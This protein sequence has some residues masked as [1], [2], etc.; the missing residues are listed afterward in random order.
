MH[1]HMSVSFNIRQTR[2][3]LLSEVQYKHF[4]GFSLSVLLPTNERTGIF[5]CGRCQSC[6]IRCC[7][8]L[9]GQVHGGLALGVILFTG[10]GSVICDPIAPRCRCPPMLGFRCHHSKGCVFRYMLPLDVTTVLIACKVLHS[11]QVTGARSH[12]AASWL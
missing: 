9:V 6:L 1:D 8:F 2:W 10:P 5:S 4:A 3:P 7:G 12:G 11:P